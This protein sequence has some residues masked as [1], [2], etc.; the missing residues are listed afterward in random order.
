MCHFGSNHSLERTIPSRMPNIGYINETLPRL[1]LAK[2]QPYNLWHHPYQCLLHSILASMLESI[3]PLIATFK[4]VSEA[5][6]KL[7]K[8]YVSKFPFLRLLPRR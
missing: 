6:I 3:I 4:T 5:Q 7:A 2:V 1:T 8:L